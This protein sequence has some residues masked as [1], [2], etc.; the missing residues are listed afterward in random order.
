MH[1]N[2]LAK[3]L[4]FMHKIFSC[5]HVTLPWLLPQTSCRDGALP[6]PPTPLLPEASTQSA[7]VLRSAAGG[8]G[9]EGIW[10]ALG[11]KCP[12]LFRSMLP[13]LLS[14]GQQGGAGAEP[15]AWGAGQGLGVPRGGAGPPG[16]VWA[17]FLSTYG[18]VAGGVLVPLP[19]GP[20]TL[21]VLWL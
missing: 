16:A 5:Y 19:P 9:G 10:S 7:P 6:S 14:A 8:Q 15:G 20:G 13:K 3:I 18:L 1:V 12:N 2:D 17:Y 21:L 4:F 11:H